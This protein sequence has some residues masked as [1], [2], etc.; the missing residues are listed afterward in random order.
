MKKFLTLIAFLTISG[1]AIFG[2]VLTVGVVAQNGS[3]NGS[4]NGIVTAVVTGGTAPY[5]YVWNDSL[6]NTTQNLT[7][8]CPGTYTVTVFDAAANTT[9]GTATVSE[10][11]VLSATFI[12]Q[13]PTS[14]NSNDGYIETTVSGG[15]PPYTYSWNTG[16]NNANIYQLTT[17]TYTLIITDVHYCSSTLTVTLGTNPANACMANFYYL[18]D[19]VNS[20]F[21]TYSFI[22]YSSPDSTSTIVSY[23][24]TFGDGTSS[25]LQNQTHTFVSPGTYYVCLNITTSSGCTST[26]CQY[27][28]VNGYPGATCQASFYSYIDSTSS[29]AMPVYNFIDQ[30]YPDSTSTIISWNW[31]FQG[32][33][34]ATS[35]LQYPT[36]IVYSSPGFY[37]ICL[38]ITTTSGCSSSICDSIYIGNN[39]CQLYANLYSQS[40]TTIGG[41]DGFIESY[42]SGGTAPYTYAWNNNATTANIYNLTSGMYT[43]NV[44]DANG[45]S[46]YFSAMLYEPYDTTGGQIIDTLTTN[47]L[48]TCL[49]FV[50]DSFNISTVVIDSINNT[51]TVTW[52]FSG[53]GMTSS[54]T[55][56]YQYYQ[57]G[58][59]AIILTINC[60][61]KALTT[62]MSF[63]HIS[64]S[65][66][67]DAIFSD[68]QDILAYPV[69]FM[70]KINIAFSGSGKVNITIYDATG[71]IALTEPTFVANGTTNKEI[72]TSNLP[73]GVYILNVDNN[74]QTIHKQVVK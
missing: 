29:P 12:S 72:N 52:V 40:P 20:G 17:G 13:N 58:N 2:Q 18:T 68:K 67:V 60:G 51:V 50:P 1:N 62:Y 37:S 32:G 46:N 23:L 33:T 65:L 35:A 41:N 27:V 31:T 42:V 66:G 15:T 43:L 34:P 44:V 9:Y 54:I 56:V 45:C 63:I 10:P 16:S 49:N 36:N 71:R 6:P 38:T 25:T 21:S 19:S 69:P 5:T 59:T 53:G 57:S 11:A 39:P 3:C 30:S 61:N 22:D 47:I 28:Y 73:S 48:D 64:A 14:S 70:D 8:L 55:V 26:S 4:C 74:G 7:N 24:W